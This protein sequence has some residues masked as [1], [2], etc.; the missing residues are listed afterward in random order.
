MRR[1]Q[2]CNDIAWVA[3]LAWLKLHEN[4][5]LHDRE[6]ARSA[7]IFDLNSLTDNPASCALISS[8][9]LTISLC[10]A[11]LVISARKPTLIPSSLRFGREWLSSVPEWSLAAGPFP[12][13][14]P[15]LVRF[16]LLPLRL[17]RPSLRA[18]GAA[19]AARSGGL[20]GALVKLSPMNLVVSCLLMPA[21]S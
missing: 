8:M 16:T 14:P 21:A 11:Q 2:I 5:Y 12:L 3:N 15:R 18:R 1:V 19:L 13:P 10:F 4:R 6:F 9:T 17:L 20:F 7:R